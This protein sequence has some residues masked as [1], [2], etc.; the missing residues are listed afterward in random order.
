MVPPARYGWEDEHVSIALVIENG[1]PS[2]YR[3]AIEADNH[4]KW[5]TT[6]DRR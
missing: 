6:M 5:I 3:K 1:D 4:G 2:S